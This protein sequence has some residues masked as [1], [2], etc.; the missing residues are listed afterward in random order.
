M[1]QHASQLKPEAVKDLVHSTQFTEEELQG[2]YKDFLKDYP[3]GN[4]DVEEFKKVYSSF[5]PKGDASKFAG[6]IFRTFDVNKDGK[7]DFREF[8]CALSVT[9]RGSVEEKLRWAFNL[10]D[11]DGNGYITKDEMMSIV[12]AVYQMVGT[13]LLL[14]EDTSSPEE[15]TEKFFEK[16]DCNK[17][18]KIS[19]REFIV[20]IKGDESL[21]NAIGSQLGPP[22]PT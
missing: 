11:L 9:S 7:M 5:F 6:H 22:S 10:Y 17:D 8:I 3:S 15:C 14:G 2:W 13:W 4:V 19:L 16:I 12:K 20:G 1:G 18:G 21:M